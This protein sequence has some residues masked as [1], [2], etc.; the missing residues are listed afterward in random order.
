MSGPM[1]GWT[2]VNIAEAVVGVPTPLTWSIF[3][4]ACE[5]GGR[6]SMNRLGIYARS[7]VVFPDRADDRMFAIFAG[8]PAIN[9]DRVR[10]IA[11]R[12]PGASADEQERQFFGFVREGVNARPSRRRYPAILAKAPVVVVTLPRSMR[13]THA[14]V[15][16]WRRQ[17]LADLAA[18][19]DPRVVLHDTGDWLED[20]FAVHGLATNLSSTVLQ[21][22]ASVCEAAGRPG[23]DNEIG[24]GSGELVEQ[25]LV[26]DLWALARGGRTMEEFL[27]HHGHLGSQ[28]IEL[29]AR[30]WREAPELVERLLQRYR[31]LDDDAHP[32]RVAARRQN[33][34]AV[35]AGALLRSCVGVDRVIARA[36]LALA[37]RL[38][39][40]RE[41]GKDSFVQGFDVARASARLLGADLA[42]AGHLEDPD[43]VFY[44]TVKELLASR[45]RDDAREVVAHRRRRRLAH[46]GVEVP[47]HWIGTVRPVTSDPVVSTLEL[48]GIGVSPGTVEGVVRVVRDADT[49]LL[50]PGEILVC[51]TTDPSWVGLMYLSAGLV[52]DVGGPLSH[53]AIIA[54]E[55]GVPCVINTGRGTDVLRTGDVVRV[56]GS[57]GAVRVLTR[58]P[59]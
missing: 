31:G 58:A 53:G 41:L 24:V 26:R 36:V 56:D 33:Q 5:M 48:G 22:L 1:T 57:V 4:K 15:C 43:D 8:H 49:D 13:R 51:A 37:S 47:A 44:L 29:S 17:R 34:K 6:R 32:E 11:D 27:E 18:G 25:R 52:I 19:V 7:E 38:V 14:A 2:T 54:R 28:G 16:R 55:L 3:V 50:E 40:L 42:G 39:P 59:L 23:L 35:A 30:S 21:R 10:A 12:M 9:V 46:Q 20:S 45:L